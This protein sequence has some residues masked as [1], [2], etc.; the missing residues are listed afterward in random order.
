MRRIFALVFASLTL[1]AL[2][3]VA[4]AKGDLVRIEVKGE[5]LTV[6]LV[7]TDSEILREFTIWYGPGAGQPIASEASLQSGSFIDWHE[8]I[9]AERPKGMR[10]YEVSFYYRFNQR[11]EPGVQLTYVVRYAYDSATHRGYMYLPGP[12]DKYYGLNVRAVI[13]DVEGH[14]FYS[15]GSWEELVRPLIA[16]ASKE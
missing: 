10:S 6:P 14:W 1:S 13:H 4:C 9:V 16:E 11:I 15:S 12:T 3:I 7:I 8:G 2:P 5:K